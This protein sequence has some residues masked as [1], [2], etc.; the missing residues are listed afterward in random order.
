[1]TSLSPERWK[2]VSPYLDQALGLPEDERATL[3]AS[4]REKNPTVGNLLQTLLQEHS[5]LA[6]E[7]FLETSPVGSFTIVGQSL[8]PYHVEAQIGSGGMGEVYRARDTRLDR[9]VAIKVLPAQFSLDPE[10][11][12]RFEREAKAISAL[13]NP[14]ICALYDIGRQGNTDYL[15]MEYLEGETLSEWIQRASTQSASERLLPLL[16]LAIQIARGLEAAH[17]KGIVHRDIKPAN[18]FVTRTGDAKILDFG[19]AKSFDAEEPATDHPGSVEP[20]QSSLHL[21]MTRTGLAV[22]TPLYWSPEQIDG[23]TIDGNK[24]EREKLDGKKLDWRTDLFSFG[25]VLYEMATSRR[26]FTGDTPDE[27]REAI[28]HSEPRP[29]RRIDPQLPTEL[30][31]IVSRALIKDREKRYQSAADLAADLKKLRGQTE[32]R[33]AASARWRSPWRLGAAAFLVAALIGAGLYYRSRQSQR[34][35]EK[36]TIVLADFANSTGDKVFDSTLKQAL[37]ITLN[38]SPFLNVLSGDKVTKTLQSMAR[39]A[40]MV[41]APEVARE[42]CQRAGSRVYI[43]GSISNLGNEYIVGLK[44]VNCR[45]GDVLAQEQMTAG[46]KEKVI[47]ALDSA[48]TK[49]RGE[50]GESLASLQKFDL[51]LENATTSSLPA[52]EAYSTGEAAFRQK[53]TAAALPY[54]LRATQLDPNFALAYTAVGGDY[55]GLGEITRA[56]E[57]ISKAFQ[58]RD[59]ASQRENMQI[60]ADYYTDVTG[61][62]EQA[63]RALHNLIANYPRTASAHVGLGNIYTSEGLYAKGNE[64][65]R[66]AIRLSG[67]VGS[68]YENL[69][70]TLLALERFDEAQQLI[71][72]AQARK[73]DDYIF[74]L[75]L[76]ALAFLKQDDQGML[77][78]QRWLASRPEFEYDGL[79]LA[80]DTEAYVGHLSKSRELT[81]ESVESAI[82]ADSKESGAIWQ[83]NAALREAAF[84]NPTKAAWFAAEGL[85]LAPDSQGVQVEAALALAMIGDASRSTALA[86]KVEQR[87]PLDTQVHAL[88]LSPIQAQLAL[89]RKDAPA[90]LAA[91][92]DLGAMDLGQVSFLNNL[93]CLHPAYIRGYAYLAAGQGAPAA[94]EFQKIIDHKGIVWNCWTGSLAHL[95]VARANA[96]QAKTTRGP[97]AD[98]ARARALI[99][100]KDFLALSKDADLDIPILKQAKAEYAKLQ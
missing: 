67:D 5:S 61:E 93:S 21:S 3:V 72:D 90:A 29:I 79:A 51:P 26:P 37:S 31:R 69:S 78:H 71:H 84:G 24:S 74:H 35:T 83:E 28:L 66:E 33:K 12:L 73:L 7:Q 4:L 34:L 19:I 64:E 8:G 50:L 97:D 63:E 96:L 58:L 45:T 15:V 16:D 47:G 17:Q 11:R 77:D 48:A 40:D 27:V 68:T 80:S 49:L 41:L 81:R 13:Q 39:P 88:W 54:H 6:G 22:G 1:M 70:N 92:P 52:L 60:T 59:H 87:Y 65:Y 53:G 91:L 44:A 36:D 43:A 94:A 56:Q 46:S 100:Y 20:S 99:A 75:Q 89:D 25:L 2:E 57:Y 42:I 14:N 86:T 9:T 98:A 23:K 30:E 76:Y 55:Y 10:R 85:K 82:R 18:V 62:L 38:Q 32:T 95:G